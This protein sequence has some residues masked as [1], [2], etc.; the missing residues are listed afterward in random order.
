MTDDQPAV[1]VSGASVR[2]G[3][4]AVWSDLS[5][6]IG[7]GEFVAVVGPNGAGKSTLLELLLGLLNP[8][9]G[10]VEVLGRRP[11][12]ARPLVSW[13]PQRRSFDAGLRLRGVDIVRMGLDGSRWGAPV[14][15][16]GRRREG[17]TRR[18]VSEAVDLVGAGAYAER[19]VGEVSGGEQ[20]RLLIAQALV[21]RPRLL[22]LDEPLE[23]LDLPSQRSV[24]SLIADVCRGGVTVVMV[25]HDVN[26]ILGYLD[27]LV[28]VAAGRAIAG[29]PLD[30]V[31]SENLS[32]LYGTAVD[33]LRTTDGR[34][35]V[36]GV[37]E[38][39][40]F[41]AHHHG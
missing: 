8:A 14:P 13:L 22:L 12:D 32:R 1:R 6:S 28:Y 40:S 37:P 19:P 29:R 30:V 23:S 20:Q 5:V 18:R 31:T 7:A 4:E 34:L 27:R 3:G 10:E 17:E 24:S 36:A 11:V 35:I 25:A 33:V 39:T 38:A 16:L 41:H 15:F 9:S 21:R 2:R 26:P